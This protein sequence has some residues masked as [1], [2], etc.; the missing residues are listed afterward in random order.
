MAE[1]L[2]SAEVVAAFSDYEAHPV[3]VMEALTA[4]RPVVGYDTAGMA[5][6]VE[7]GY[8]R[9]ILPGTPPAEAARALEEA[10]VAMPPQMSE[11]PTWDGCAEA[12]LSVY[13]SVLGRERFVPT[14]E[15]R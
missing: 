3:A 2:R 11:L 8:V 9:G 1:T 15:E 13:R 7:D 5:D 6:L 14:Q 12:L 10:M 4:G